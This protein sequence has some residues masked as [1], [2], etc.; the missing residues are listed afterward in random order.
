MLLVYT[1]KITHRYKYT[2]NLI[3]KDILGIDWKPTTD[4]HEFKSYSGPKISYAP[5]PVADELFFQSRRLLFD[6][7][8]REQEITVSD[9]RGSKAFF[10][11]GRQSAFPFD[12]F[13]AAF[14]LVSRY[15]EY[16]PHIRDEHDRFDAKVSLACQH[17]FLT[18]PVVNTWAGWIRD[19]ISERFPQLGFPRQQY[20]YISTIDID[21]AYAYKEKGIMRTIGGYVRS[22]LRLDFKEVGVRTRVLMGTQKDPYDTYDH[23]LDIQKRYKLKPIYFFL[24]GDYGINDKN[25]PVDSKKFHSL[26]K[27][28]GDYAD[29]GIHP[30]FGSN[31]D[32]SR[33]KTE[34][35]RLSKILHRDITKS[36]QHFLKLRLPITY[37]NLIDLDITDDYTMGYASAVGFRAGICTPFNFYD[38]DLELETKLKVHPFAVM[39]AT[40][41]YYM[42]VPP[43][44]AI[45][46]IA[47]LIEEVRAVN[48]TFITLW[49]NE[50]LCDENQWAGWRSLYEE[51]VKL[52]AE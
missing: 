35:G 29:I 36:R 7:G 33:L 45:S 22:L 43:A 28:I 11:A 34:I 12:L 10:P 27:R 8:I 44:D 37:R 39:E 5:Q 13:A 18:K 19:A 9:Y 17:G 51:T 2:F 38:L 41:K 48:G 15:E 16:L 6:T 42:K 14:Y 21:N 50:T 32:P 52:A 4:V 23:L 30:S 20:K 3:F 25:L 47:P 26:I 46:Y 31:E 40:L 1:E 49:H 24:L